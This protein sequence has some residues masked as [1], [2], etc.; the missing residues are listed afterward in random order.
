M[1]R[2]EITINDNGDSIVRVTEAGKVNAFTYDASAY[3][4]MASFVADL[5][6]RKDLT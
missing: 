2:I 5:L 4:A 3:A 6:A 1:N